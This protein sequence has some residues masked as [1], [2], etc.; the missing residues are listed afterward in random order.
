MFRQIRP[1]I[2]HYEVVP[3]RR[4]DCRIGEHVGNPMRGDLA[5]VPSNFTDLV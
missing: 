5:V 4:E 2:T 1:F 3:L